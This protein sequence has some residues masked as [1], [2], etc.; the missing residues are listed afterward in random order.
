M[1]HMVTGRQ[2][3][4]A[5]ALANIS[6]ATLAANAN[7]SV[8]TLKRME[9]SDGQAVGMKNNVAAVIGALQSAGIEFIADHR[10]EGVVKLRLPARQ[11]ATEA[12]M[13]A[14]ADDVR[15]QAAS[16][17]DEALSGSDATAQQKAERRGALTDEPAVVGRARGKG[18]QRAPRI[19]E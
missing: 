11:A 15:S 4:A 6:Q 5:R 2:I 13:Q 16:A 8:P 14:S 18:R 10:G 1:D 19:K 3:A 12:E 7:I 17:V 9:A